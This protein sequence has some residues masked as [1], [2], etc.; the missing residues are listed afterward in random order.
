MEKVLVV[1]I[2]DQTSY[3]ISLREGLIQGKALIIFNS[4]KAEDYW[5]GVLESIY[6]HP[7]LGPSLPLTFIASPVSLFWSYCYDTE[8]KNPWRSSISK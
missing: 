3:N 7:F 5:S 2:E 6:P 4:M 8:S 1:W